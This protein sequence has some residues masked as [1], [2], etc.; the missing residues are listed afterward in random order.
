MQRRSSTSS[1]NGTL[2]VVQD[3]AEKRQRGAQDHSGSRTVTGCW[4]ANHGDTPE[5][6]DESLR[7][8]GVYVLFVLCL[9]FKSCV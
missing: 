6:V 9:C 4:L 3:G 8:F 2:D 5:T 1:K 7:L